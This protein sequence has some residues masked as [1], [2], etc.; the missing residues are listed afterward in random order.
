MGPLFLLICFLKE[1]KKGWITEGTASASKGNGKIKTQ[2]I[3]SPSVRYIFIHAKFWAKLPI[4]SL[5]QEKMWRVLQV[6]G[7]LVKLHIGSFPPSWKSGKKQGC[8]TKS[9]ACA[10]KIC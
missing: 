4:K 8:I 7:L 5:Q 2:T 3:T 6:W 1:K 10:P 9:G